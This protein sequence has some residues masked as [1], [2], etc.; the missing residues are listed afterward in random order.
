MFYH[1][2]GVKFIIA[3]LLVDNLCFIQKVARSNIES[4]GRTRPLGNKWRAWLKLGLITARRRTC[5]KVIFLQVSV[6]LFTGA[7]V[8][9]SGG[10]MLGGVPG[11]GGVWS[12]AGHLPGVVPVS[13]GCLPPSMS[14]GDTPDCNCCVRYAS[15]WNAILF[16]EKVRCI[17]T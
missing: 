4:F 12:G 15:Y 5:G 8:W 13:R 17:P 14:D 6:I 11:P 7:G 10:C 9:S 1:S 16:E 3:I 2:L